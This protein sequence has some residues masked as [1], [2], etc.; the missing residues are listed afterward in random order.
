MLESIRPELFVTESGAYKVL[1]EE[2][3][4]APNITTHYPITFAEGGRIT[5]H[6]V[7]KGVA[8][9]G[10]TFV[11][12]NSSMKVSPP[13]RSLCTSCWQIYLR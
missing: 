2:F 4:I 7:Y 3:T 1:T 6:F 5:T 13:S 10:D 9:T 11:V 8:Q 12:N